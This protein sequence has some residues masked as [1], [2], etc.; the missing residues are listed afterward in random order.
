MY[1]EVDSPLDFVTPTENQ[2]VFRDFFLRKATKTPKKLHPHARYTLIHQNYNTPDQQFCREIL[3]SF[4][5]NAPKKLMMTQVESTPGEANDERLLGDTKNP[6]SYCITVKGNDVVVTPMQSVK[7]KRKKVK[8]NKKKLLP[9]NIEDCKMNASLPNIDDIKPREI[10]EDV[11]KSCDNFVDVP[12]CSLVRS[13][14]V[15]DI[16]EISKSGSME[17]LHSNKIKAFDAINDPTNN[18]PKCKADLEDTTEISKP[19]EKRL[20]K[21]KSQLE[22]IDEGSN[23]MYE[24]CTNEAEEDSTSVD[25]KKLKWRFWKKRSKYNVN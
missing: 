6:L 12:G 3:V 2:D 19:F 23:A 8:K 24:Q 5:R 13:A 4:L 25:E 14:N 21:R 18:V 16:T 9:C 1:H 10:P 15:E 22:S 17:N 7:K 20:S 11:T